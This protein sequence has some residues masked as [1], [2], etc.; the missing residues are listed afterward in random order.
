MI[1]YYEFAGV[2]VGIVCPEDLLYKQEH[3]LAPFAVERRAE[4]HMFRFLR[5]EALTA[6]EGLCLAVLP[7]YR[8]YESSVG[9]VRYV[10]AV[11]ESWKP[12]YLRVSH[13]ERDYEVQLLAGQFPGRVGV[14]TVLTALGA[15]HLVVRAGGVILHASYIV[16]DG[17]AILFTAPSETGKSTQAELWRTLRGARIV[18]GDR[19][20]IRMENGAAVA[21][22]IPFAGSSQYCENVTAPLAAIVCLGQ[23]PETRISPLRGYQAF[24]RIWEGCSVNTWDQTDV[25]MAA[26]LLQRVLDQVPVFRLDCTPDE[27]AVIAL[28]NLLKGQ[29]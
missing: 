5:T 7:N 8:V 19:V 18:N 14:H 27:S 1:R 23:A 20:A 21:C 17:R 3:R 25:E 2:P 24:R 15:E 6:P 26:G 12:A 9:Q 22:G 29:V 11:Q 4:A 28:E 16:H 13:R 10:G